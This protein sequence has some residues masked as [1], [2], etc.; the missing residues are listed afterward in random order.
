MALA[1]TSWIILISGPSIFFTF[2]PSHQDISPANMA[3]PQPRAMKVPIITVVSKSFLR[4]CSDTNVLTSGPRWPVD[5]VVA[6]HEIT[7]HRLQCR[8][9]HHHINSERQLP[10]WRRW[11][12]LPSECHHFL[13]PRGLFILG[14]RTKPR[15]VLLSETCHSSLVL[16]KSYPI[17]P[18]VVPEAPWCQ[19]KA[20]HTEKSV[21]DLT[22]NLEPDLSRRAIIVC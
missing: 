12:A 2:R 8:I 16:K 18:V 3:T 17:Q 21:E 5:S 20:R 4:S 19:S 9:R 6:P 15:L 10:Q 11:C 13:Q 22:V 1:Y 7:K 14:C